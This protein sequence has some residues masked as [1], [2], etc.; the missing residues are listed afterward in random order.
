MIKLNITEITV[1]HDLVINAEGPT[2][3][4]EIGVDD[5]TVFEECPK[6]CSQCKSK[7]IIGLEILGASSEVLLW[8]CDTCDH[9]HLKLD[10][11]RTEELLE[12][13]TKVWSNPNDWELP[14]RKEYI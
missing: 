4:S 11:A 9:L 5:E 6:E 13:S 1:Y 8:I 7:E 10:K 14:A 3:L 2:R 12:N